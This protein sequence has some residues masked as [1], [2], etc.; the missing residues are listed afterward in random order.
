MNDFG[1]AKREFRWVDPA[2]FDQEE[3]EWT[4]Q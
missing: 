1:G 4:D 2:P 3:W